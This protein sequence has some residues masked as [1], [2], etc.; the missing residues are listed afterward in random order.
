MPK[1]FIDD[2]AHKISAS[3][4]EGIKQTKKDIEHS[5]K[6]FAEQSF[7]KLNLV[8]KEEFEITQKILLKSRQKIDD[9]EAKIIELEA[10]IDAIKAK[11]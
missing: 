5:V 11:L 7:S 10:S 2:L 9:L 4:P 8:T 6:G 1:N 3:I